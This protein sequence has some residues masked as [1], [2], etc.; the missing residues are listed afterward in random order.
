LHPAFRSYD[1]KPSAHSSSYPAIC[2][3][4]VPQH[5]RR[6]KRAGATDRGP[7]SVADAWNPIDYAA[8][9]EP[10]PKFVALVADQCRRLLESLADDQLRQLALLKMEGYTNEEIAECLC[11]G[12]RSVVRKLDLIRRTWLAECSEANI[13][14]II[15]RSNFQ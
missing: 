3:G 15:G 11:C 10:T 9:P 12:L 1:I 5:R 2:F 6:L 13:T 8:S 7:S 4:A 14:A